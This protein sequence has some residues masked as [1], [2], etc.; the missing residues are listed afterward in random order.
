MRKSVWTTSIVPY[1]ADQTIYVVVDGL[2]QSGTFRQ[3][4]S[5][6][7]TDFEAVVADL[8]SGTFNDPIRVVAFNT[9][10]HWSK[11]ISIDVAQ[12]I[13]CRCDIEGSGVPPYLAG[14]LEPIS[15]RST[16]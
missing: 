13:Q 14:F 16:R 7:R 2:G 1:G 6:E 10:E 3:E 5:V 9:L 15:A 4:R 8:M 11:D 12:E